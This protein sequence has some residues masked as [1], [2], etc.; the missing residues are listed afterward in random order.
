MD[1]KSNLYRILAVA[2]SSADRA[3]KT[4]DRAYEALRVAQET[5]QRAEKATKAADCVVDDLLTTIG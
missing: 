2:E 3:R 4:S 5:W 1:H